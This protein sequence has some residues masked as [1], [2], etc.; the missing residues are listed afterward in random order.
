M[1][2]PFNASTMPPASRIECFTNETKKKRPMESGALD[3][4][5]RVR[6]IMPA[7][8]VLL[9]QRIAG[10]D[11]SQANPVQGGRFQVKMT[12]SAP[13]TVLGPVQIIGVEGVDASAHGSAIKVRTSRSLT[14]L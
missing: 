8:L 6:E 4:Q 5:C 1:M 7:T 12:R 11:L 3:R 13:M 14:S 9:D 10:L 2:L